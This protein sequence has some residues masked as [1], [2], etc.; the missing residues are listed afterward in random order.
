VYIPAVLCYVLD[1][2]DSFG[3]EELYLRKNKKF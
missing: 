1:L 2:E 3:K